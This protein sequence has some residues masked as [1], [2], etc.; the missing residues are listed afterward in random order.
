MPDILAKTNDFLREALM[1]PEL[2]DIRETA[3][4]F[5]D[6]MEAGLRGAPSS[7]RM[8]PTYIGA[9]G[10][11]PEDTPVIAIDAGGTNLR[12]G[13]VRFHGGVPQ[14]SRVTRCAMPGSRG[15]ISADE[16]FEKLAESVFPLT[17][18]SDNIG[19]CF[20]YPAEIFPNKD[21]KIL[22]LTKEVKV[23]NL[24]GMVLGASLIEKLREMGLAKPLKFTLLNDTA[25]SL[26]GGL[27]CLPLQSRDGLAGLILGTGCNSCYLERGEKILKLSNAADMIVNCES[28][29]FSGVLRGK[30]DIMTDE[31]SDNPGKYWMEKMLAGVYHGKVITNTALLAARAGLLTET[32]A[33][34]ALPPFQPPELDEFLLGN[35]RI[36][37]MC[38]GDDAVVLRE[39]IDKSYERAARLVCSKIAALCLHCNGGKSAETPFYVVAEGSA[40][41]AS[42]LFKGKLEQCLEN[43]ILRGINRHAV[44]VSAE[45]ATLAG[46]A[47][48][49]LVG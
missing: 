7:L 35:G 22:C 5:E 16:F 20:S 41:H 2:C 14:V 43:E 42:L 13:L 33:D 12:V 10:E 6:E 19:F 30:S 47:L 26:M 15:E 18:E 27:A 25:A 1:H 49:A 37:K 11:P 48:A 31:A 21:G 38:A 45:N 36:A 9:N 29:N 17:E 32:F 3:A 23:K 40:F 39:I 46:A 4:R 34:T 44:C 8:I 24:S 28:G